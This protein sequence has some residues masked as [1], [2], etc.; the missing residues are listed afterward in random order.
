[1]C[2]WLEEK[3]Q[4]LKCVCKSEPPKKENKEGK[5]QPLKYKSLMVK[6]KTSAKDEEEVTLN[7]K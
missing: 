6:A 1:M 2:T 4:V 7:A 5:H 3:E